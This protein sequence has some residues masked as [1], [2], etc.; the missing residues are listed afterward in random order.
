MT[1]LVDLYKMLP[2]TFK[3]DAVF[4][5][6]SS[7][8]SRRT[9]NRQIKTFINTKKLV[10]LESNIYAK[11]TADRFKVAQYFYGGYIG[12]SS[13]LYL[14]GLKNEVDDVVY[15]CIE[16]HMKARSISHTEL[17][18]IYLGRMCFGTVFLNNVLVSS[19]AKTVFDMLHKPKYANLFDLFRALRERTLSKKDLK[20]LLYYVSI[21]NNLSTTRRIGYSLDGIASEWF[22]KKLQKLN[23]RKGK[24]FFIRKRHVNLS[25]EWLLYDDVGIERWKYGIQS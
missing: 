10:R 5:Q 7:K 2:D 25:K 3:L 15:V 22:I 14:Y 20:E 17:K 23:T 21:A 1:K 12:F 24:S 16:E 18:P 6:L 13:A 19:Y 8:V 9:I 11:S 4:S